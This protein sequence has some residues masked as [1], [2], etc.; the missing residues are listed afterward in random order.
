MCSAA[1]CSGLP[2]LCV[3]LRTLGV[4]LHLVFVRIVVTIAGK[5]MIWKRVASQQNM[6]ELTM[7]YLRVVFMLEGRIPT[8]LGVYNQ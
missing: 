6:R 8:V 3:F 2:L 1:Q 5:A 4:R 7:T